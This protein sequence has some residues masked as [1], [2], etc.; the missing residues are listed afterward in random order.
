MML[1]LSQLYAMCWDFFNQEIHFDKFSFTL[2]QV[3][4]F[5]VLVYWLCRLIF[6]F[7]GMDVSDSKD[8]DFNDFIK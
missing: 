2:W 5:C 4:I 1:V 7:I 3:V 6:A 8:S